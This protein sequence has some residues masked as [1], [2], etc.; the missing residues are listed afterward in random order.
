MFVRLF[1][2]CVGCVYILCLG[3]GLALVL[4]VFWLLCLVSVIVFSV[5]GLV[6]VVLLVFFDWIDFGVVYCLVV[7]WLLWITF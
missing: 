3:F 6:V 5:G 4:V 1:F 7:I 2:Y